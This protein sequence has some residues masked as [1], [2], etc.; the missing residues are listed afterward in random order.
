MTQAD[1][2]REEYVALRAEICQSISKQHEIT[3]AGYGLAS[4]ALGYIIGSSSIDLRALAIIPLVFL[5]MTCLWSVECNRMVRA[6]YYIGYV[7]WPEMCQ[8]LGKPKNS[9]WETWIRIRTGEEGA[10]RTRQ[11][12]FQQIVIVFL[13]VILSLFAV[14][15]VLI[16]TSGSPMWF[17]GLFIYSFILFFI[18]TLVYFRIRR[19]SD[20]AAVS[21]PPEKTS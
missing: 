21:L 4:A 9:G 10:F 8:D 13:P 12:F 6:S 14:I 2:L 11:D 19:I 1:I 20:L 17:W 15:I 5:A 18:W 3:I 7:L 16:K